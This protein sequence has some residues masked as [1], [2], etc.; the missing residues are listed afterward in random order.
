ME[1]ALSTADTNIPVEMDR[2][3]AS[4]KDKELFEVLSRNYF[5][6]LASKQGVK[7]V[8]SGYVDDGYQVYLCVK[9][10]EGNTEP[11]E[12]LKSYIEADEKIIPHKRWIQ[13]SI[14]S[15]K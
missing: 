9:V 3:W 6:G 13:A 7:I 10:Q 11:S 4:N 14:S 1:Y 5:V 8:L 2:F 12:G 15:C